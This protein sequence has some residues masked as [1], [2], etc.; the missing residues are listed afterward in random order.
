MQS[1]LSGLTSQLTEWLVMQLHIKAEVNLIGTQKFNMY[2]ESG[3][4]IWGK[5]PDQGYKITVLGKFS[6]EVDMDK[7]SGDIDFNPGIGWRMYPTII[8]EIRFS[9]SYD[10]LIADA[11]LWLHNSLHYPVLSVILFKFKS[12][13][14]MGFLRTLVIGNCFL[15]YGNGKPFP[16]LCTS[17]LLTR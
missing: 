10:R 1:A 9:E 5:C 8:V 4:I 7:E 3:V 16:T 13:L 17:Q 15:K 6:G 2:D 12:P 14:T 11:K